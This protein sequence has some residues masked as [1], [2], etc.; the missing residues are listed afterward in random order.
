MK[1][2]TGV[3]LL[4]SIFLVFSL[5]ALP[6]FAGSFSPSS[7][8]FKKSSAQPMFDVPPE[9]YCEDFKKKHKAYCD[10]SSRSA[11]ARKCKQVKRALKKACP[12][13]REIEYEPSCTDSDYG[14]NYERAGHTITRDSQGRRQI[15]RDRC[16]GE[17]RV[18]ERY[19]RGT[20][21]RF[22][23][24]NCGEQSICE[25]GRCRERP[26][27]EVPSGGLGEICRQQE[28]FCDEGLLCTNGVCIEPPDF[29]ETV[30]DQENQIG[31]RTHLGEF[32][33][34]CV[35]DGE[36]RAMEYSCQEPE[37]QGSTLI[38]ETEQCVAGCGPAAS[39]E[40][41]CEDYERI[42]TCSSEDNMVITGFKSNCDDQLYAVEEVTNCDAFGVNA[43][44]RDHDGLAA[45]CIDCGWR[46]CFTFG[47]EGG[48]AR[49]YL[50]HAELVCDGRGDVDLGV[51]PC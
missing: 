48:F 30:V 32:L 23:I 9:E 43:T 20:T 2:R 29:C 14:R 41:C 19:C 50:V 46:A 15:R 40:T 35:Q 28:P 33:N 3:T 49:I 18:L 38:T 42:Y 21:S 22:V 6:V 31:A 26:A 39:P 10:L 4:I 16:I 1:L 37:G 7:Y 27:P 36:G 17:T 47:G 44:C 5:F 12:P 8:K 25:E 45:E 13:K 34:Q 51:L 11:N 24:R